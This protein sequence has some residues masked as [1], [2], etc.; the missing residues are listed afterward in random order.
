MQYWE[1]LLFYKGEEAVAE[2]AQR[3]R[4]CPIAGSVQGQAWSIWKMSICI[5]GKGWELGDPQ[6]P[7][8]PQ[9][10]ILSS[11]FV[12]IKIEALGLI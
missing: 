11:L 6:G 9:S 10:V 12:L 1:E 3:S 5:H 7:Y 2:V 4:G 8:H